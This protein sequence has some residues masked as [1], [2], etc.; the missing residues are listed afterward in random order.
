MAELVAIESRAG[1][2][3]Y[4]RINRAIALKRLGRI[5][6]MMADLDFLEDNGHTDETNIRVGVAA[7]RGDKAS[8][9]L[10]ST[11]PYIRRS[12]LKI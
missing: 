1:G 5:D 2:A 8:C 6:E 10:H 12:P 7:L 4:I 11:N 9:W 3:A